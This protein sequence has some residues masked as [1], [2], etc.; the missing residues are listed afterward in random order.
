MRRPRGLVIALGFVG[1]CICAPPNDPIILPWN[2]K[3][4]V[5]AGKDARRYQDERELSGGEEGGVLEVDAWE[6]VE[7]DAW[8]GSHED[9]SPWSSSEEGGLASED[10]SPFGNADGRGGFGSIDV[11]VPP[12][13]D[14]NLRFDGT[15]WPSLDGFSFNFDARIDARWPDANLRWIDTGRLDI[16]LMAR[17][18][19]F[20]P[21]GVNEDFDAGTC[22]RS[23]WP[24]SRRCR[25]CGRLVS[26]LSPLPDSCLPRCQSSTR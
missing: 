24:W 7:I 12:G 2:S 26:R 20:I 14:A 3:R 15:M 18:D 23:P 8:E 21:P 9:G 19:A 25:P 1:G 13:I 10:G 5:D 17:T 22:R 4:D 6:G 11:W 16:P